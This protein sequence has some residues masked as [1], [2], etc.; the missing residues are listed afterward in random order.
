MGASAVYLHAHREQIRDAERCC[1]SSEDAESAAAAHAAHLAKVNAPFAADYPY[2]MPAE[3]AKLKREMGPNAPREPTTG[4]VVARKARALVAELEQIVPSSLAD[5]D[6]EGPRQT[7][8]ERLY[9]MWGPDVRLRS[10]VRRELAL[11]PLFRQCK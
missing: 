11:Q 2:D 5:S 6:D 7:L 9:D 3:L 1:R 10:L 8:K 4:D